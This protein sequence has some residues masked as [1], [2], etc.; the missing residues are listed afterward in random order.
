MKRALIISIFI[1]FLRSVYAITFTVNGIS[2]STTSETAVKVV[3]SSD[4]SG[5]IVLPSS[6][7]YDNA[8]YSVTSIGNEAFSYCNGL[9][10]ITIPSSVTSIGE[11]AF[12]FSSDLK[13]VNIPLSVISIGDRAFFFC[14]G[15]TE[16]TLPSSVISIGNQAFSNCV[17][18]T[19]ITIPSS[20]KSIGDKAFVGCSD[21]KSIETDANNPDFESISGV[22]YDKQ[23][24][25]LIAFPAGIS[26]RYEILSSVKSISNGAFYGCAGLTG[27][28]I[29]SSVT[30]IGNSA[31]FGCGK[32]TEMTIPSS[33][34]EIGSW[35]Y[36]NCSGLK[37]ITIPSSLN[38]IE[39][40]VF[41]GCS[42]LK[43]VSMPSSITSIGVR[44]FFK[45]DGLKSLVI[46]SSVTSIG[47]EA[48]SSCR[49][50]K[51]IIVDADNHNF[52]CLSGVL[53]N[54]EKTVLL[55]CPSGKPGRFIIPSSVI[56]INDL[57]FASCA[58]KK[59]TIPSSVTAVGSMAFFDC[60]GLKKIEVDTLNQ[61]YSSLSGVLYNKEKT[62]LIT[63]PARKSGNFIIPS[64]VKSIE[65]GAFAFSNKLKSIR[66]PSSVTSIGEWSFRHCSGLKCVVI[67]SSIRSIGEGAFSYCKKL[68]NIY[69]CSESPIDLS[70]FVYF[71]NIDRTNI[72]LYVPIGSKSLYKE[73][74][75]WSD[76]PNIIEFEEAEAIEQK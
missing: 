58:L 31:F 4:Y 74:K 33:V 29:P 51:S 55:M 44:S 61:Y 62:D 60:E 64:S 21:L 16:I 26:G 2:Y 28:T 27:V 23:K 22:L 73:A 32:L 37:S 14:R 46:P 30:S 20:V 13:S 35:A 34:I 3:K 68:T 18:L 12:S 65:D 42:G 69:A 10:S 36:Y 45:C 9:T 70:F 1:L 48:F 5:D 38:K 47:D 43:S 72:K 40:G 7:T 54:D 39:N 67:P 76:F 59:V 52:T 19:G 63:Y 71:Y 56:T 53:Y 41:F 75:V 66:I 49:S 24:S 8:I 25:A 50:L 17:A 57:A 11:K 6:V 15:L